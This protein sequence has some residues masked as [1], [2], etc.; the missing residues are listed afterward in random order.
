MLD[1]IT[2]M[3]DHWHIVLPVISRY[4]WLFMVIHVIKPTGKLGP[5]VSTVP[6]AQDLGKTLTAAPV[7]YIHPVCLQLLEW[8]KMYEIA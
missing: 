5:I 8:L 3:Y 6:L 4:S 7:S 2:Y 1:Y